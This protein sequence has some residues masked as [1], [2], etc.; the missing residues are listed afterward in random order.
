MQVPLVYCKGVVIYYVLS[1]PS[2]I[3]C[4]F[5]LHTDQVF[6]ENTFVV[7]AW[8]LAK[9]I[10]QERKSS[11]SPF[12]DNVLL[13]MSY[14]PSRKVETSTKAAKDLHAATGVNVEDSATDTIDNT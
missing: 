10:P 5:R 8:T 7:L 3:L 11:L 2:S 1:G 13:L 9:R 14:S 12:T 4:D 6:V